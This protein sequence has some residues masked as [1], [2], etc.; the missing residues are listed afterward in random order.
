MIPAYPPGKDAALGVSLRES[1]AQPKHCLPPLASVMLCLFC[2]VLIVVLTSL[3]HSA[4]GLAMKHLYLSPPKVPHYVNDA[5]R[6]TVNM[7]VINIGTSWCVHGVFLARGH[8][9]LEKQANPV[10]PTDLTLP[11]SIC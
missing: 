2:A 11:H 1:M 10:V 3:L 5:S 6:G 4:P 8:W 9:N 7:A